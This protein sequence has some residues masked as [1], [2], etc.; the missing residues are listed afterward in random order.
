MV[1]TG[2]VPVMQRLP[3]AILKNYRLGKKAQLKDSTHEFEKIHFLKHI[4]VEKMKSWIENAES[5][6]KL[7]RCNRPLSYLIKSHQFLNC[8]IGVFD[9]L[10]V[11]RPETE[12]FVN[13]LIGKIT[14]YRCA[15]Y[16]RFQILDIGCGTG[17]ISIALAAN[18]QCV[19]VTSV[20][21]NSKACICTKKNFTN[22]QII[23]S[24]NNSSVNIIQANIFENI[25]LGMFDLIVSNP[26]YI[27]SWKRNQVQSSVLMH[28]DRNAL[29][30][31]SNEFNGLIFHKRI[32][33]LS[34]SV[35]N[36]TLS[37][38]I[39]RIVLEFDGAY[40]IPT[41]RKLLKANSFDKFYF[42]R[43][44]FSRFRTLWIH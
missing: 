33:E 25:N 26:P 30:P 29:F 39:P 22:N 8:N 18:L 37:N 41:F 7:I 24:N 44:N 27:P 15:P 16:K 11:P 1:N 14:K 23:I 38:G 3:Y 13:Y 4:E 19:D 40:Q 20:D 17:C 10:L 43:D 12:E 21:I 28:E 9:G 34:N 36:G 32:L 2:V 5:L 35:L 42:R 31:S 6:D